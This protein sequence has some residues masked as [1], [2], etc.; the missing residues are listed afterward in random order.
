MLSDHRGN[1]KSA[2]RIVPVNSEL[3]PLMKSL[4]KTTCSGF[5]F[6]YTSITDRADEK[7]TTWHTQQLTRAKRKAFGER[8]SERKVFINS[9]I[10]L[11]NSSTVLKCQRIS[12][13]Y[14]SAVSEVTR[15]ASKHI[16]KTQQP[17]P[18]YRATWSL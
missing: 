15:R 3:I 16:R 13:P 17:Q 2:A 6:Y 9:F 14:S 8:A 10:L 12:L 5:I 18:S 4:L 1:A 11:C 7:R